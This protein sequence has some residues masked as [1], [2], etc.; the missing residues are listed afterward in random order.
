M[1]ADSMCQCKKGKC[2]VHS[3]INI[4]CHRMW[5]E[6]WRRNVIKVAY[7]KTVTELSRYLILLL[8]WEKFALLA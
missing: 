7:N 5:T 4:A 3:W 6:F 2:K 8:L 1:D